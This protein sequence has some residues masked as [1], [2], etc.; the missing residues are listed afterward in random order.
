MDPLFDEI[1][2]AVRAQPATLNEVQGIGSPARVA[3]VQRA[4][5]ALGAIIGE[6]AAHELGHSFGLAQPHGS[7]TAFHSASPGEGCL[8]DGGFDRPLAERAAQPGSSS[9]ALCG[10]EVE[11]L[12]QVLP[13]P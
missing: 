8:M 10:D 6:T 3:A 13:V 9:S 12:R 11:Y 4:V 5:A 7:K 2:D 1:F